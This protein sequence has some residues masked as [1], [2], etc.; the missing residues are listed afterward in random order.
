VAFL[1]LDFFGTRPCASV[2]IQSTF[3]D[4][5]RL[6]EETFEIEIGNISVSELN[7]I[8]YEANCECAEVEGLPLVLAVG[9]KS[10]L[11]ILVKW[12]RETNRRILVRLIA[13]SQL[14]EEVILNLVSGAGA[15]AANDV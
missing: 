1:V 7:F 9:E 5:S 3:L 4:G 6:D 13:S 8:S 2:A 14:S 10:R 11:K 12:K 15:G